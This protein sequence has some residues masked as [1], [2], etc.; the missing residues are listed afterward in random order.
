MEAIAALSKKLR[1]SQVVSLHASGKHSQAAHGQ[2]TRG[3]S[4]GGAASVGGAAG[5]SN[6]GKGR[7]KVQGDKR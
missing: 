2:R 5:A 1:D 4:S 7:R 3:G 6:E